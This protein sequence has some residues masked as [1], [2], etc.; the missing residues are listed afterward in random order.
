MG[1]S[2]ALLNGALHAHGDV[3]PSRDW[4]PCPECSLRRPCDRALSDPVCPGACHLFSAAGPQPAVGS[5]SAR[6]LAPGPA[7]HLG[8]APVTACHVPGHPGISREAPSRGRAAQLSGPSPASGPE[9]SPSSSPTQKPSPSLPCPPLLTPEPRLPGVTPVLPVNTANSPPSLVNHLFQEAFRKGPIDF[10][11]KVTLACLPK[12]SILQGLDG[13]HPV[14]SLSG[15]PSPLP[16]SS[17][18][19]P[20][21][22]VRQPACRALPSR[23]DW[24]LGKGP[25]HSASSLSPGAPLTVP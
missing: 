5:C 14:Q 9:A 15:V 11:H 6:G 3:P 1:A 17:G 23:P 22:P 25:S 13:Y 18:H 7:E 8:Q 21:P 2:S 16:L 12:C 19:C 24:K 10:S 4:P 20:G